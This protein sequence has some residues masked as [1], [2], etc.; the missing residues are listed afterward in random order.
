MPCDS[1]SIQ[2]ILKTKGWSSVE[3][4]CINREK[5]A[6]DPS[7]NVSLLTKEVG[8]TTSSIARLHFKLDINCYSEEDHRTTSMGWWKSPPKH[9]L[10]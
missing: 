7:P 9:E 4:E 2:G 3:K 6:S 5:S 8:H 1:P 10:R